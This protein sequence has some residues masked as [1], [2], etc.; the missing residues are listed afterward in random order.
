M[1]TAAA[2][3]WRCD[4]RAVLPE[5]ITA[6][7]L[8]GIA[9]RVTGSLVAERAR[10]TTR[11]DPAAPGSRR[12]GAALTYR[13]RQLAR[14]QDQGSFNATVPSTRRF[15]QRDGSFNATVPSTRRFLQRDG[16]FNAT[17]PS[18]RRFLRRDGSFD[19]AR[20]L[21]RRQRWTLASPR[22]CRRLSAGLTFALHPKVLLHDPQS[23]EAGNCAQATD[24]Q[25]DGKA[26]WDLPPV[27]APHHPERPDVT[28]PDNS[29][30]KSEVPPGLLPRPG[31]LL[32]DSG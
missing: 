26:L 18:T 12:P 8:W 17:V 5:I 10:A 11:C 16:S 7:G 31:C 28:N 6:V 19:T 13:G 23:T 14:G 25:T 29:R 1:A 22:R 20:L 32:T 9:D 2:S 3:G 4:A 30:Q 27:S 21:A 15:L 24:G